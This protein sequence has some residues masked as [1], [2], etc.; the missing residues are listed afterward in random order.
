MG[1]FNSVAKDLPV[2]LMFSR[3]QETFLKEKLT[4]DKVSFRRIA[5]A[6]WVADVAASLG[7][8]TPARDGVPVI[9]PLVPRASADQAQ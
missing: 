2:A 9:S 8:Y 6:G 7:P 5:P 3:V 4:R 1:F